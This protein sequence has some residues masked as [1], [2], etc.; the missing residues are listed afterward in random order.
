MPEIDE[1]RSRKEK[2]AK[3]LGKERARDRK[4]DRGKAK[5]E[6]IGMQGRKEGTYV[7]I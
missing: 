2:I 6:G 3:H 7:L 1:R 5:K 4:R